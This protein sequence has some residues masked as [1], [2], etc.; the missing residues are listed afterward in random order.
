MTCEKGILE[1]C[2]DKERIDKVEKIVRDHMII[3]AAVGEVHLSTFGW[4]ATCY[5][6]LVTSLCSF[7]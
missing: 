5:H 4:T 2:F 6:T 7:L 3:F 1:C